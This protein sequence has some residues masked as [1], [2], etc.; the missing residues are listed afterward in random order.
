MVSRWPQRSVLSTDNQRAMFE[1]IEKFA[2]STDVN[3]RFRTGQVRPGEWF[4]VASA[5]GH[6]PG[7]HRVKID[8]AVLQ[9]EIHLERPRSFKGRVVDLDGKPIAGAFVN[10]DTWRGYRCLGA[11]KWTDADGRF[12]WDDAPRDDLIVSVDQQGYRGV[13]QRRVAPSDEDV[14]F[15]LEPSLRIVGAVR[16]AETQ[17]RVE[18]A[19][20]EFSAVDPVTGEPSSW[21]RMPELGFSTG[22]YLGN[23]DI[24]FPVT[25]DAY[26]FRVRSPGFQPFVS[27]TFKREEKVVTGYDISLRPGTAKPVGAVAT[28]FGPDGKPLGGA[29]LLEIQYGGSVSI[30]NGVARVAQGRL[31]REDRTGPDGVF[32]IPQFNK[33]WLLFILGDDSYAMADEKS[34]AQSSKVQA[35]PY[36]RIEGQCRIGSQP[37]PNRELELSGMIK[38]SDGASTIFLDQKATT[39][40][41][42][43]FTFQ[44]V[45]PASGVRIARRERNKGKGVWSI[46]E[47][48]HV[49]PGKTT[50]AMIGGKGRPVIG[51]VEP[52]SGWTRPIDFHDN[53]EA[54][55]ESNRPLTPYPL[56][57]FRG[58]TMQDG[59]EWVEW[60]RRWHQSPEGHDY[61]NRRVSLGVAL[62]PDGSFRI[63]DVPAGEYRLTIR[64]NGESIFHVASM[65]R[66]ESGPFSHIFRTFTVPPAPGG[67]SEEPLDLGELRLQPRRTFEVGEPA[68]AFDVTTV[69][70]K[71]LAVPADFRGK[72]L[73]IDF[74]TLWDIEAPTQIALLNEVNQKFGKDPRFAILSLTFE[75]D[76]A[77][78]R[79]SI[80]DKGEPWTQA[81]VGP[82][83]NPIASAYGIDD[84]N[85]S[86]AIL[87]GPDGKIAAKDLWRDRI[88]K[89]L[90]GVLGQADR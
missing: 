86:T 43:R 25:A 77:E 10:P 48:V 6:A 83:S 75:P 53:S 40:S 85:V 19:T 16:N 46:G 31:C 76:T 44:N 4:L 2:V 37:A 12:R 59:R 47:P 62:A 20:V 1:S 32:S 5:K 54:H 13:S 11:F 35:R 14:V 34:L 45:V 65:E 42:G 22:I 61:M 67:R 23:L 41:E 9:V 66:R 17:A 84:E 52:P 88:A 21:T 7:D 89:A 68:P 24:A 63:D 18:N 82:L 3:G 28:V 27:R 70:G 29:R 72:F 51:R 39:D 74:G 38:H 90:D 87:I 81:I 50:Q 26:Q 55:I 73:L 15:T 80:A 79:K 64:V 33:P 30:E 49:E 58:K 8:T 69:D 78:S 36:A 57:L 60:N 56:S 71:K